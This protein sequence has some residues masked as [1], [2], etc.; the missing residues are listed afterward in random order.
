MYG[1]NKRI[2]ISANTGAGKERGIS[3]V[4]E[5]P[6]L[7][8]SDTKS[9]D[10]V[11]FVIEPDPRHPEIYPLPNTFK[12]ALDDNGQSDALKKLAPSRQKEILRYFSFLKA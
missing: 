1:E 9:G 11:Q 12:N 6:M 5:W 2:L 4:C 8:G 3:F 7:K 10:T